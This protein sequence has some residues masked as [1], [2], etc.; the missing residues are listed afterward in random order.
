MTKEKDEFM[1]TMG[2]V[3]DLK[4]KL[5]FAITIVS[6][7]EKVSGEKSVRPET[8]TIAAN[9]KKMIRRK[10]FPFHIAV[11]AIK[12]I[13]AL[14][15]FKGST[16]TRVGMA[17]AELGCRKSGQVTDQNGFPTRV[18]IVRDYDEFVGIS[19]KR[20]QVLFQKGVE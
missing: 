9:L 16:R 3:Y 13:L 12:D 10:E 19:K 17:L 11:V 4:H 1:T 20:L 18:W 14:P 6:G 15:E 7:K 8:L 2:N 5:N